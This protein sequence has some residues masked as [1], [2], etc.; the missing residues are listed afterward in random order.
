[1]KG[2]DRNGRDR[3]ELDGKGLESEWKGKHRNERRE[4][5]DGEEMKR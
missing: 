1:M 5:K 2:R 4:G 3:I